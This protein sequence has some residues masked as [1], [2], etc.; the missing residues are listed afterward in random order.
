MAEKTIVN[1]ILERLEG[2]EEKSVV[3]L[4]KDLGIQR[5]GLKKMLEKQRMQEDAYYAKE[6]AASVYNRLSGTLESK[7]FSI[8]NER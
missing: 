7:Q 3:H 4:Q 8:L 6:L 2:E 5:T 1:G